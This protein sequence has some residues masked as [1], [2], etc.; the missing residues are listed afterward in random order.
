MLG[1]ALKLIDCHA[2]FAFV[3]G[4]GGRGDESF[5]AQPP[6][7]PSVSGFRPFRPEGRPIGWFASVPIPKLA[8]VRGDLWANFGIERTLATL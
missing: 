7:H 2:F 5:S 8:G 4:R 1:G 3:T 6:N